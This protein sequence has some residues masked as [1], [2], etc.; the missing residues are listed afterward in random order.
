M[1]NWA[2]AKEWLTIL[3]IWIFIIYLLLDVWN[4]NTPI[5]KEV[6][7]LSRKRVKELKKGIKRERTKVVTAF[8]EAI[9]VKEVGE[10]RS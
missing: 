9:G 5:D 2:W 3:F 10:R 7:V 4:A 8:D 1:R 6:S